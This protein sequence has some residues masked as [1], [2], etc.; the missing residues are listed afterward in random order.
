MGHRR[1]Y[2]AA[3]AEG[4]VVNHKKVQR[5]WRQEGLS[6]PVRRRRKRTGSSTHPPVHAADA[7]NAVWATDFQYDST[8]DGQRP[9][10][11]F[12]AVDEHTRECLGGMVERSI[13][14]ERLAAELDRIVAEQ[15]TGRGC[16]G[17][18]TDRR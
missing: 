2:Q 9:I 15:G 12:S 14:V 16:C 5:L 4:W 10:K 17:W 3:R 13:T 7:P 18:T 11:I 1:A 8:T 6:V